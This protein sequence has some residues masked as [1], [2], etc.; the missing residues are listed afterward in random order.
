MSRDALAARWGLNPSS[1]R[2]A[3]ALTH[4]SAANEAGASNERL[5]FLGDALI[6]S[7]VAE[8]LFENLPPS[9]DEATL[10]RCRM[11][12]VRKETLADAARSL[13]LDE[14]LTVGNGERID[15]RQK[16][17]RLLAD[18]YEALLAAVYI[19]LGSDS[20]REF[21]ESTLGDAL[22]SVLREP[23]APDPKSALQEFLQADKRGLPTYRFVGQIDG[24]VTVEV[25]TEAGESL[26]VGRGKSQRLAEREAARRALERLNEA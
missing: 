20:A 11:A 26:A 25:S 14:L 10:S 24:A 18:A 6:G 15:G 3:L 8:W 9:A 22:S 7:L 13:G 1:E 16:L 12:V 19:D 2:L 5:E 17:D 4:R 21:L 23:P